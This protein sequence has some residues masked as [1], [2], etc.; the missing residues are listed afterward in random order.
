MRLGFYV[1]AL[2]AVGLFFTYTLPV[3]LYKCC[4][5]Q[6]IEQAGGQEKQPIKTVPLLEKVIAIL[7]LAISLGVL[8]FGGILAADYTSANWLQLLY[9]TSPLL[10]ALLAR[11]VLKIPIEPA[12]WPS[13]VL[14]LVG[15]GMVVYGGSQTSSEGQQLGW[16]DAIGIGIGTISMLGMAVFY[17]YVQKTEGI[18]A[19][20]LV[21]YVEYATMCLTLPFLSLALEPGDW[22]AIL[23]Y[24]A[25]DWGNLLFTSLGVY[26]GMNLLQQFI[27]RRVGAS[28]FAMGTALRLVA[29]IA[30]SWVLMGERIDNW[31]E[32]AGSAIV[33]VA[34]TYYLFC[35]YK[36]KPADESASLLPEADGATTEA[37]LAAQ[38]GAAAAEPPISRA[39]PV[40]RRNVNSHA[41][42]EA[43]LACTPGS[44]PNLSFRAYMRP[45]G[46]NVPNV[47]GV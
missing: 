24:D 37:L 33:A 4:R 6:P 39:V 20:D 43:A 31:E 15:S 26:Y 47:Q 42:D 40:G 27:I 9:M 7:V 30:G 21:L 23:H 34:I 41:L 5:R 13:L 19:E 8:A 22:D 36:R 28:L 18:I 17:V 44:L 46:S 3:W 32:W 35:Q 45:A 16:N 11:A 1:A 38:H 25:L 10:V 29:S 14:T 2:A 12:L